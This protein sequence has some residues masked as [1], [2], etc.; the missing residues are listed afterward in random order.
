MAGLRETREMLLLAHADGLV[1]D[2]EFILLYDT[3]IFHT[4]LTVCL[5]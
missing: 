2:E 1:D 4:G 3:Q 5:T